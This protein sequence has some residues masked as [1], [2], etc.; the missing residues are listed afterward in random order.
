MRSEGIIRAENR[1][2]ARDRRYPHS[3][4]LQSI[5]ASVFVTQFFVGG[6]VVL[7]AAFVFGLVMSMYTSYAATQ[8]EAPGIS[9]PFGAAAQ[10]M[11]LTGAIMPVLW[12]L[13][14]GQIACLCVFG[15]R[16]RRVVGIDRLLQQSSL[17]VD[18]PGR[19]AGQVGAVLSQGGWIGLAG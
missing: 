3:N 5:S 1:L 14:V 9:K 18:K 4:N 7:L 6:F 17:V 8:L 15:V 2:V 19:R 12:V 13:F 16:L 10:V 11:G